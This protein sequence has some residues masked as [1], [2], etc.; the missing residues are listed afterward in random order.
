MKTVIF[1]FH[2][3]L[4]GLFFLRCTQNEPSPPPLTAAE[5]AKPSPEEMVKRGEYLVGIMGCD[6]CHSPKI[7]TAQGPAPDPERRLSGHPANETLPAITD[8][9]MIGPGQWAL[10]NMGLTGA[11]GPW[12]TSFSANLT[13]HETGIGSWKLEQF[14]KA[15]R[16]GKSKGL[17]NGR[18]LLPPMPWVNYR[19]M[20]DDDLA[21]VFSFLKSLKP[22]DNIPPSPIPPVAEK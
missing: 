20:S 22:V 16:E 18:M 17:D 7:M 14:S 21:A 1:S 4:C 8:K 19:R 5:P 3:L 9:R 15:L 11:V 6:D 13:P 10:F 2:L 12:G